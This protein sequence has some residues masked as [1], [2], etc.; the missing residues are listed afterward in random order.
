VL[1]KEFG[2]FL[3]PIWAF[4]AYR[5]GLGKLAWAG[6]IA[7]IVTLV[8]V[9]LLRRSD[10]ALAFF[11]WRPYAFHYLFDYQLSVLRLRGLTDYT[12]LLYMGWWCA[13]WPSILVATMCLRS[14]S[15][16]SRGIDVYRIGFAVLLVCLPLLLLGDWSRN[17]IVLVPFASVVAASHPLA[18]DRFFV[19]LFAIGGFTTALARPFHGD[20]PTPQGIVVTVTI[21]SLISSILILTKIVRF[22]ASTSRPDARIAETAGAV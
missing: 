13:L 7:P 9:L 11:G 14:G 10:A 6:L 15:M 8:I 17:L 19:G 18:R 16:G 1:T 21:L 4:Y 12:K 3:G 5:R 22:I 20:S 2:L